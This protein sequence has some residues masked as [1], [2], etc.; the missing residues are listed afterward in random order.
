MKGSGSHEESLRR[1]A[2]ALL[3]EPA[4]DDMGH[5]AYDQQFPAKFFPL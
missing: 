1:K 2:V 3:Q 4:I 5:S